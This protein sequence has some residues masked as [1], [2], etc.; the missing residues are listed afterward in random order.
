MYQ[1][2]EVLIIDSRAPL[3]VLGGALLRVD[4]YFFREKEE[5]RTMHLIILTRAIVAFVDA[6]VR[7]GNPIRRV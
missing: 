4:R 3:L 7:W 6:G 2:M 1:Q 5:L